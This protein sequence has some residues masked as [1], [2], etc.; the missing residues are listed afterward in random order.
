MRNWRSGWIVAPVISVGCLLPPPGSSPPAPKTKASWS[1][2]T[3]SPSTSA[4]TRSPS[5]PPT[6]PSAPP[7][8]DLDAGAVETRAT[9]AYRNDLSSA[10]RLVRALFVLDGRVVYNNTDTSG[11]MADLTGIDVFE[12]SI[13]AGDHTLQ[14]LLNLQGNGY[15][16]FAYLK[17]YHFEPRSSHRFTAIAG[18]TIL[19]QV[20]AYEKGGRTTQLEDRLAVRYQEVVCDRPFTQAQDSGP[21]ESRSASDGGASQD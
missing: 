11:G 5:T 10:F 13:S 16:T 7:A 8:G 18:K 15:G 2:D 9:I 12:G 6:C 17:S 20:V 3:R 4:D 14:I 21:N 19:V 1:A